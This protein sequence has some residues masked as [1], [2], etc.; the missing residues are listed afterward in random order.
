MKMEFEMKMES[1][2]GRDRTK[3]KQANEALKGK[4]TWKSEKH[5]RWDRT[6]VR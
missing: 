5:K 1:A 4:L 3:A 6:E 2:S